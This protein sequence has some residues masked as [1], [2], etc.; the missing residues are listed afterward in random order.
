[1]N[2][3]NKILLPGTIQQLSG[4]PTSLAL[5]SYVAYTPQQL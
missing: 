5:V 1:M 3:K 2:T 4:I